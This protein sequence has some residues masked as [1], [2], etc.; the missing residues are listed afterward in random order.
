MLGP[1]DRG[2]ESGCSNRHTVREG[3]RP[4]GLIRGT[5]PHR[6]NGRRCRTPS[7][8]GRER[9]APVRRNASGRQ[10]AGDVAGHGL[11]Q[12]RRCDRRT[13]SRHLRTLASLRCQ[14][15]VE[16]SRRQSDRQVQSSWMAYLHPGRTV[17]GGESAATFRAAMELPHRTQVGDSQAW[18]WNWSHEYPRGSALYSLASRLRGEMAEAAFSASG[19]LPWV[20]REEVLQ[21]L[22]AH[23]D[24][25][26]ARAL[27]DYSFKI[28]ETYMNLPSSAQIPYALEHTVVTQPLSTFKIDREVHLAEMIAATASRL[29]PVRVGLRRRA[30]A[31]L[32]QCWST[33]MV[34]VTAT[35]TAQSG[36]AG[37]LALLGVRRDVGVHRR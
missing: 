2:M 28:H 13:G 5:A 25:R 22:A 20:A 9:P 24:E 30:G 7:Q 19:E 10:N 6:Q 32:Q 26:L 18:G 3:L 37:A 16:P 12:S 1:A 36:P 35:A 17:P 8:R 15:G 31:G 4:R 21:K 27:F 14:R 11:Q 23:A 33:L 29:D 34:A